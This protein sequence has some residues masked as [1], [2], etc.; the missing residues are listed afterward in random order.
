M[1]S[2]GGALA[3]GP[4]ITGADEEGEGALELELPDLALQVI[5]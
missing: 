5:F 4:L 3:P 2:A 1:A